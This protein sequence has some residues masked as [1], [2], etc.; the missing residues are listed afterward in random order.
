MPPRRRARWALAAVV[1]VA[2]AALAAACVPPATPPTT[3]TAPPAG[4]GDVSVAQTVGGFTTPWEIAF[5]PDGTPLVTERPGRV[6]AVVGGARQVVATIS[7]VVASGEGGLLGLAV[8]PAFATNRFIYTCY[9]HG[10]GGVV[11]DVRIVRFRVAEDLGSLTG[12][13]PVLTGIPQGAGNRHQGCRLA[14][15]PDGMLWATTGDAAQPTYPQSTTNLAGKVLRMTAAGAPAPGNPG[16]SWNPYVYSIGHRNGQGLAFR[17]SDGQPF[18][19]EHGTGCDD[20]INRIVAGGNYGWNPVGSG[21][22]ESKPMTDLSIPGAIPAVWS[23]GCPTIA[24]SGASFVT[25]AQWGQWNGALA[26]AVLKGTRLMFVKISGSTLQ[27]I[28]TRLTDR[29]RLRTVRQAPD[30][31]LWVAQDANPGSLLRLVPAP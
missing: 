3:T 18:E 2:T 15:G 30:G 12:Q 13:T 24:P 19:V 31:S 14:F 16:G 27:G 25:G 29:G 21:Y 1:A 7:D 5:L 10:S 28:D 4:G 23:S 22:D 26:V 9:D 17:P 8:D 6:A 20:E 11:S